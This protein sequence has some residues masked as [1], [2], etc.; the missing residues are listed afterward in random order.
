LHLKE[1]NPHVDWDKLPIKIPTSLMSWSDEGKPRIAGVSSFGMGGTNAHILLEE[2]PREGNRHT[3]TALSDQGNRQ[4][5]LKRPVHL[6]TL[7]A[8][9]E[10]ALED[11]V[12]RY[13]TY[14]ETDPDVA[15][16]EICYT[17]NTGRKHFQHRLAVIASDPKE[18]AEKLLDWKRGQEVVGLSCGEFDR[19]S[20]SSKIAFLFTGQGS[21]YVNMGK[22]LYETVPTFRQALDRCDQILQPYLDYPLLE[23]LYP[24]EDQK[25]SSSLLDQTAY[26]QPA[27]FAIEYALFKLW[28][29]WGIKPNVVMG[30]SVGEY[31]AATVAGVFSLEEGLK[32]IA[33]RGR[34]MQQLPS[35]GEM[36][37]AMAS[38]SVVQ[39]AIAEYSA[40]VAIA[41][42]NGPESTV[43]SGESA[44]IATLCRKLKAMGVKTK[45]LQVSHAFHSPLMEPMLADFA[46]VAR[47]VTYRQPKIKFVSNTTGQKA[48]NE[49]T[50]AE[51]WV[52]HIRQPVQFYQSIKTLH[53]QG[54]ELFLE[55]GPKPILL[56]M[57]S[58]CLL[59]SIGVWLPSLRPGVQ[60]W[61]QMLSSLGQLYVK[62][63]TVN[64]SGFDQD[65]THKK[66]ALPTYPFQRQRCW[67]ERTENEQ[68]TPQAS[69]NITETQVVK[70]LTQGKTA[71][72]AQQLE[73][74][75]NFSPE[76]RKLLPELLEVLAKQ[77]QEQLAAA[78]IENWFYEIQWKPLDR[79]SSKAN[80]QPSHWLI[81]ADSTGVAEKIAQKL[82]QQGHQYS[83]VYRSKSY[84]Q[85]EAGKYQLNPSIPEEFDQLYQDIQERNQL[86]LSKFIHLWSLDTPESKDLT[87]N[88]LEET[89]LWGC[90]SVMHLVQTLLKNTS[91]PQ[92]WLVTRGS[93]S[94]LSKDNQIPGLATSPLWG[95]GRVVSIEN[96]QLWGG[97]V[98]LDPQAPAEDEIERLWQLLANEP[99]EDHLALRGEKTYVARLVNQKPPEFSQ[100]LSLL[101][102]GSYLITGGLGAL[103]RYTAQWLV[104]K[105]AKNIVLTGRRPPSENVQETI[106]KLEQKGC[107]VKVLLGDVSLEEEIAK[108]LEEIQTSMPRLKGIIHAAGVL[109]DG[110]LQQM[111]WERFTKV[112]S[113]KVIGTWN[114][115][116]LTQNLPLDFF[117]CFSSIASLMGSP[118]QGNYA[119]ANAFMDTLASYRRSI[120]LSGLAINWGAWA[121]EGMAARLAVEYQNRIQSSGISE[122][123]PKEGMYALDIL[124]GNQ[125][126]IDR[127]GVIPIQWSVL[128][129]HWSGIQN[130]SLLRELLQKEEW[131]EQ[132]TL[133]QN[134]KANILA[135]LEAASPEERQEILIEHIRGQV[136]QV[137]GL[138]SSQL[139]EMNV[140]F[141][142]MGMDSLMAVELKNRL[143]NQ[144]ETHLPETIAMEY[145]TV[146]K[147]SLYVEE[148]MEW[149]AKEQEKVSGGQS[150]REE[151]EED[152]FPN[153]EEI[154]EEDFEAL[155][156]QQLETL[157]NML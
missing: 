87:P 109:D 43:I 71:A 51:Y 23:V 117:V 19:G 128:A 12:S 53:E 6:L 36:V 28:E 129:E 113:P 17:A 144:L 79:S 108:I 56:G 81:F 146:A 145:P 76:Q 93:Q 95:L 52:N 10:Q 11:L 86:P 152:L 70:L 156:A 50:K 91:T 7:S 60:E 122:I 114:L 148:L 46:A 62:G 72:I 64:W 35:G 149:Q 65:F 130:S 61:Q 153:L 133:K 30:H 82:Q 119:A 135:K 2:A 131:G 42:I 125:S 25:S 120:G 110:I 38:K 105:G 63:I 118:G 13:Q 22:Q 94:V 100:P 59:E 127:V 15:I 154:S 48:G 83:L 5:E 68:E 1:P 32:L 106:E 103:G 47:E 58:R 137:L 55:I 89:Q 57:G 45:H 8:K 101:S 97:L 138:S 37:A 116:R 134:V 66:V 124:L 140:G 102:E 73:K 107:Q 112:M 18:L 88:I 9:T 126:S 34:L 136:V 14:L 132:D 98:D 44:A 67:V 40:Q 74:A 77:H 20:A 41:A 26:T 111:D 84:H 92:L 75:V 115:H 151:S 16:A 157:K 27:L 141:M 4:D 39:E 143:Q 69:G 49:V 3:S 90:G 29:S 121:S 142:E 78:A 155:A 104:E 139:P 24:K 33:M 80:L 31:V 150:Q 147:L 85:P 21:Q 96:P 123:S 99:E 54:N